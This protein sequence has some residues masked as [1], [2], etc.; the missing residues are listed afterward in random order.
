[1]LRNHPSRTDAPTQG[2]VDARVLQHFKARNL[3]EVRIEGK[4]HYLGPYGSPESRSEY[5]RLIADYLSARA[6]GLPPA[7]RESATELT[8]AELIMAYKTFAD[9]FYRN[10]AGIPTGE[11]EN[12]RH[13]L[14]PVRTLYGKTP[15]R[16]FGPLALKAVRD[17]MVRSGRL[18]RTTINARVHRIRRCFRWA[19][20]NEMI[21]AS[22]I[23]ALDAVAALEKGRSNAPE[24]DPVEAVPIDKVEATL[25]FLSRQVAAMVRLQLL[26]GMRAGEV[27]AMRT[28]DIMT[29]GDEWSYRPASHKNAWRNKDRTVFLGP[30]ARAIV[31]EFL[32]PD[33][34]A[35]LFD[36]RDV[37]AEHHAARSKARNSKRTP[38]ERARRRP[39]PGETRNDHYDRRTYRQAVARACDKAFPHPTIP[40]LLRKR[41]T[42]AERKVDSRAELK[43]WRKAQ[44]W[45]PLQ[46]RHAAATAIRA[47][48]GLEAAQV[49]LGHARADTTEIYAERDRQKAREVMRESG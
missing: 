21:P 43:A 26:T 10:P 8:V 36:P 31:K 18:S 13:A 22:V 45:S 42:S 38:A 37:V 40:A 27:M 11:V 47:K 24:P 32:K 35:H 17:A 20:E 30:Q 14:K 3:A 28:G 12:L 41:S 34:A 6:A 33:P 46:L 19:V 16:E 39:R 48:Y 2:G 29:T 1:M 15:A 7:P 23:E 5:D 49:V 25:P 4:D 44:R 9:G